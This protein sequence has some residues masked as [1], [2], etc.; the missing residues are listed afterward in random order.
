MYATLPG[1]N[2]S[3]WRAAACPFEETRHNCFFFNQPDA[4][5]IA[6]R[7]NQLHAL[8]ARNVSATS[9]VR[10]LRGRTVTFV[11]DSVLR[12]LAQAFMCH[13]RQHVRD[14]GFVWND[15]TQRKVPSLDYVGMCPF[16]KHHCEMRHGCAT[17]D[18]GPPRATQSRNETLKVCG[19]FEANRFGSGWRAV[20]GFVSKQSSDGRLPRGSALVFS[21]G[22][23][24][25]ASQLEP[26]WT[27]V[28][29]RDELFALARSRGVRLV[30]ERGPA[31]NARPA[32]S[33]EASTRDHP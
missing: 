19:Y 14:V 3:A 7:A 23:H 10:V 25:T 32:Q 29:A 33:L 30:L 22:H 24:T 21:I 4:A 1:T 20:L 26:L 11:G 5:E 6:W 31:S 16:G 12:Q 9:A 27:D 17:F 13:L 2:R 18:L 28:A 8:H 15:P